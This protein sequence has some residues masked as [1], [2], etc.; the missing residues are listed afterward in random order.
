MFK[1]F[2]IL[3]ILIS[4]VGLIS[5][6]SESPPVAV[7]PGQA[8]GAGSC[9]SQFPVYVDGVQGIQISSQVLPAGSYDYIGADLYI[10]R[11][12]DGITERWQ[13][14]EEVNAVGVWVR[15]IAC[16]FPQVDLNTAIHGSMIGMYHMYVDPEGRHDLQLQEYFIRRNLGDREPTWIFGS[17]ARTRTSDFNTFV[18]WLNY[19]S[20]DYYFFTTAPNNYEY[21]SSV[22]YYNETGLIHMSLSVRLRFTPLGRGPRY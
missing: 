15:T 20:D 19:Y 3:F 22:A 12:R 18:S 8:P 9:G 1:K 11:T 13:V 2:L 17:P 14:H 6:S 16:N 5:C 7:G 4:S 21:R 10:D